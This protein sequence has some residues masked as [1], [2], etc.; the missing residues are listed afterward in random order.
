MAHR[1]PIL[2]KELS[3]KVYG[4]FI[5][6]SKKYGYLYK[7]QFYQNAC[8]ELFEL[9]NIPF[10]S[11]PKIEIFSQDT[12]K[13][14]TIYVPDFL[15]D[16]RIIVELKAQEFLPKRTIDQLDQYLKASNYEIGYL[17][18]F[19]HPR[20]QIVRHIYTN[21]RKPWLRQPVS[22]RSVSNQ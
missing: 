15:I 3:Y 14:L 10:D 13:R 9:K 2:E 21:D 20:A 17:V 5:E 11:Q 4:I 1:L 12:G 22:H 18:N 7:E 6:V 19:G 8:K 16:K